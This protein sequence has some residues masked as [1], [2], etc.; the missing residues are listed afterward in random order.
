MDNV[1][2]QVR[3]KIMSRIRHKD[4]KPEITFRRILYKEG[5]RY[6]INYG[7]EKIDLA[8]PK[9]KIAIFI[10]GCFWHSCP[11][12]LRIPKSNKNYWMPKLKRNI[13]LAK[14]KDR[15][16]KKE[17]WRVIHI[18]EHELNKPEIKWQNIVQT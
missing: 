14:G 3:S 16:L 6:R 17:G 11:R 1:S 18:W 5:Y 7:K 4:T 10:D 12:H 2:K 13:Q 8:F 9:K 15:R